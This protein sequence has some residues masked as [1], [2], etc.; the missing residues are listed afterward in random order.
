MTQKEFI[1]L[2]RESIIYNV[3]SYKIFSIIE[4]IDGKIYAKNIFSDKITEIKYSDFTK[5]KCIYKYD[6]INKIFIK[7]KVPTYIEMQYDKYYQSFF[8]FLTSIKER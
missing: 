7:Y 2:T 4:N 8:N 3:K 1:S 5:Y 6:T